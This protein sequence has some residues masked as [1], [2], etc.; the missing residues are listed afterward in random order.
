MR[1]A[2]W[3][4]SKKPSR[5]ERLMSTGTRKEIPTTYVALVNN[6]YT[7]NIYYCSSATL[8]VKTLN[9]WIIFQKCTPLFMAVM[10]GHVDVVVELLYNGADPN[11]MSDVSYLIIIVVTGITSCSLF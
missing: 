2:I 8:E 5:V 1:G 11:M 9:L 10:Y 3:P 4:M 7:H 6:P